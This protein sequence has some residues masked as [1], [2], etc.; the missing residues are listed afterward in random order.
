MI[1]LEKQGSFLPETFLLLIGLV[2]VAFNPCHDDLWERR[3]E[4]GRE[5]TFCFVGLV[6]IFIVTD[7]PGSGLWGSIMGKEE[8]RKGGRGRKN[9][10]MQG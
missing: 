6:G 2:V 5:G 4:G 7:L 9:E 10:S 1:C 8:G 3:G